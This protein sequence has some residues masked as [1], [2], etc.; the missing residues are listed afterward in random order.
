MKKF[1]LKNLSIEQKALRKR[2]LELSHESRLSH[3]GSCL[4]AVDIINAVYKVKKKNDIFVLSNG[5][6]GIAWYVVLERHGYI[7]H[8]KI[9]KQFNIHPDRNPKYDIHVS[10]G[11]LGQGLP[12]AVGMAL[13]DKKRTVYCLLSDGECTEGSIW[14]SLRV[15]SE[16]KIHNLKIIINANGWSAYDTVNLSNLRKRIKAFGFRVKKVD[17]HDH[18]SLTEHYKEKVDGDPSLFFAHTHVSQFP[19]LQGQDAHYYVMQDS[20]YKFAMEALT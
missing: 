5:H 13:A 10:T 14:E 16:K 4:S 18:D 20:D 6:A 7:P 12:I 19:F 11:S 3:L 2:I 9:I 8:S 15:A 17:G 1:S